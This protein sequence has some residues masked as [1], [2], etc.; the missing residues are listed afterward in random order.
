[1]LRR[2]YLVET[3]GN[4]DSLALRKCFWFHNEVGSWI[5]GAIMFQIFKLM[6]KK[7][8]FWEKLKICWELL[9]H[10]VEVPGKVVLPSN[11]IHPWKMVDFL[12]WFHVLPPIQRWS[13]ISPLNIPFDPSIPRVSIAQ[14]PIKVIFPNVSYDVVLGV[15][16]IENNP[17]WLDFY[18]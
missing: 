9:L 6:R 5:G 12:E 1:M 2:I 16:N 8:S 4:E 11:L 3:L 13:D 18:F 7:P 10:T 14:L 17:L 15:I